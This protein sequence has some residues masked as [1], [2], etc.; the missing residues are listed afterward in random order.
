MHNL[1][2]KVKPDIA[3]H[4]EVMIQLTDLSLAGHTNN[5]ARALVREALEQVH[6]VNL[7]RLL[8]ANPIVKLILTPTRAVR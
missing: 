5:E 8:R 1:S 6:G 2:T 7:D 4:K 3:L